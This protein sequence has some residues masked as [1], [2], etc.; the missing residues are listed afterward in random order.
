VKRGITMLMPTSVQTGALVLLVDDDCRTARRL[1]RML[2]E[3]GYRVEVLCDGSEALARIARSPSP[4][5]VV[6][7]A[8]VPGIGGLLLLER[9]HRT[10]PML[11]LIFVTG[12]PEL[13]A[14]APKRPV[15]F[16]KPVA[17]AELR[18]AIG[19]AVDAQSSGG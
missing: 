18:D 14:A 12:Y 2:E 6:M 17:Y 5:I 8:V 1:G 4:D 13:L 3:D 16:T 9:L 10:F 15:V 19:R 7:D 11:P